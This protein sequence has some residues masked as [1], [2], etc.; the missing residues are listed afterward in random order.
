MCVGGGGG[1]HALVAWRA[2]A[3]H[4]PD[5]RPRAQALVLEAEEKLEQQA[6]SAAERSTLAAAVATF[7]EVTI[8]SIDQP[9]LLSRLSESL[10]D[11][12]LNICEAHAF[13][14]KDRFS[15]D[16]FVVNGWT[17]GGTEELEEVLSQR[18]QELP[19][20]VVRGS[21]SL[22]P[23][24]QEAELRIPREELDELQ[25]ARGRGAGGQPWGGGRRL[26]RLHAGSW[27]TPA[28]RAS[29]PPGAAA[30]GV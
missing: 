14:T 3:H 25:K 20:P 11:L 7:Y 28:R 2:R 13:N 16:V 6:S 30:A 15:L 8:A 10:G 22:S 23:T 12:G 1:S 27:L 5:P 19:P 18:L 24:V 4:P 9:K 29:H 21:S 17:G 26:P